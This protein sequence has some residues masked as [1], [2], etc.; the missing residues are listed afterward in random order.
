MEPI[1]ALED[2]MSPDYGNII[3]DDHPKNFAEVLKHPESE[4]ILESGRIEMKQMY[5]E[6]VFEYPTEAEI[7]ELKR[8]GRPIMTLK[9]V[10]VRKYESK[11][12]ADGR[13]IDVFKKWKGRLALQGTR[14]MLGID[15]PWSSFSPTI[16]MTAIRTFMALA[17]ARI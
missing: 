3:K 1:Q 13:I 16:G 9:M 2:E 8:S 17:C 7:Q 4:D 6:G 12:V 10:Y 5:D 11:K 14:E 15:A